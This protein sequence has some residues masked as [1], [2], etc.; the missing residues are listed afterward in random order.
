M[1][2]ITYMNEPLAR[3]V[4]IPAKCEFALLDFSKAPRIAPAGTE[5]QNI[6]YNKQYSEKLIFESANAPTRARDSNPL[7]IVMAN[8]I[9][10]C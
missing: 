1:K 10:A 8:T 2:F 7:W 9:A 3:P 6:P 5:Q 4:I